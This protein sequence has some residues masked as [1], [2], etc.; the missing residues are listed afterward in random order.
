MKLT[1]IRW[2]MTIMETEG[3]T[4]VTDPVFR[5]MGVQQAPRSY[6]ADR[7]PRPDLVFISH[8]HIDHFS[9]AVLKRL[10]PTTPVWMPA[11]KLDK[12]SGLR[13][14][15]L[16]GVR[17]WQTEEFRGVQLTAV[18]AVHTGGE[19]GLVVE[20]D[21]AVYFAGDTSLDRELFRAIGQRWK[22]DAVLLPIGDLHTLGVP[23][24]HIGP[25]KAPQALRLLGEPRIV[26]PT[27]YSGMT[28][29]PFMYFRGTPRKLAEAIHA[30]ELGAI[31]GTTRPLEAVDF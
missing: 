4:I 27:H 14:P 26:V 15:N 17:E 25:R 8:T 2:S 20:G 10:D 12:A 9:P 13:L 30:A 7:M 23:F 5:M 28:L 19:L 22:L 11:G 6:T 3:L 1:Y 31:V 21:R 18:P 29:G 24:G 16:R